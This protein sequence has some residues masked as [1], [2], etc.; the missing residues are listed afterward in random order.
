MKQVFIMRSF[1]LLVVLC[2]FVAAANAEFDF[3]QF[4]DTVKGHTNKGDRHT[5]VTMN[6]KGFGPETAL[7]WAE[8]IPVHNQKYH[9]WYWFFEAREAPENAPLI[10]WMTGGPGCSSLVALFNEN[11]P[12]HIQEDLSLKLN[13]HSWNKKANILFIDQPV[14]T[15]FSYSDFGEIGVVSEKQM[16]QAMYEFFQGFFAKYPQYQ[17]NPFFV[18]GESYA[19]HYIPALSAR[20]HE[21]NLNK[22]GIHINLKGLAIGNGLVD[23]VSQYPEYSNFALQHGIVGETVYNGM[24]FA[25]PACLTFIR[26]CAQTDPLHWASCTAAYYECMITQVMPVQL[27]GKRTGLPTCNADM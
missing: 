2:F 10:L 19:G 6:E 3:T 8:Y 15:G 26:N 12:Y 14:G 27:Q 9:M 16:A 13:P 21:G 25:L 17:E 23:P 22:E 4:F 7:N 18:T 1:L 11:G 24:R 5:P 20:I